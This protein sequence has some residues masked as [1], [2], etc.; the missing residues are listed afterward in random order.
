MRLLPVLHYQQQRQ[1]DCLVACTFMVLDY[2]QVPVN[3][4]R[5]GKL[6]QAI[7]GGT[8]FRNLRHI[9]SIGLSVLIEDGNIEILRKHLTSGLPP[10]VAVNTGQLL[11]YW[12]EQTDHAVVVLGIEDNLI[13]L[14]DPAFA[15]APQ[16]V[17]LAEFE[18]AW[19][20]ED[21]LYAVIGL[22]HF[23]QV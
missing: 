22:T 10:I 18:L 15:L 8:P 21:Y 20:D 3:Y 9:K 17:A 23:D 19:L 14:N 13:Y 16:A 11:S 4:Q 5:V 7:S 1:S 12:S 6:L 2:L